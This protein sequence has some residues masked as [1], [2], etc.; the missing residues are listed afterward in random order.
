MGNTELAE[1]EEP[2]NENAE[3]QETEQPEQP[4]EGQETP[5]EEAEAK[6][7]EA[8]GAEEKPE[9]EEPPKGEPKHKRKTGF[10]RQIERLERQIEEKDALLH[11]VLSNGQPHPQQPQGEQAK[12]SPEQQTAAWMMDLVKQGVQS[13]LAQREQESS[14]R[15][16]EQRWEEQLSSDEEAGSEARRFLNDVRRNLAPGPVKD[17][18][19]TSEYAPKII[20]SLLRN[21]Q[22]L[23]R[24]SALPGGQA[25]RE[26]GRLEAQFAAGAAPAKP[27]PANRPPAPPSKLGGS[28]ATSRS[29]DDMSL[30]DYKRA[31]RSGRR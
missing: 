9:G 5:P 3:P 21:P 12:L 20:S 16:L 19:L 17:A 26:I 8:E 14:A 24:L 22:E 11:R 4:Q 31:M 13:E 27:K 15:Q 25:A 6:G 10:Q 30:A 2:Q 18:L 23:A 7:D 1:G 28:N 29:L